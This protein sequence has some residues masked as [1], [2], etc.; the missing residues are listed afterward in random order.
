MSYPTS[1]H[2]IPIEISSILSFK[3]LFQGSGHLRML[4]NFKHYQKVWIT[5]AI[6]RVLMKQH[7]IS[8]NHRGIWKGSWEDIWSHLVRISYQG[9]WPNHVS[10][11]PNQVP[12]SCI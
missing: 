10:L 1:S 7:R 9:W 12:P 5:D 8:Y 3:A 11:S 4:I 2:P 6:T